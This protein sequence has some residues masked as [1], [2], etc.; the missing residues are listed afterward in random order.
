MRRHSTTFKIPSPEPQINF[1]RQLQKLKNEILLEALQRTLKRAK[2][3]KLDGDLHEFV[4]EKR[5]QKVRSYGMSGEVVFVTPY[6]LTLNPKLIGYYRLLI[7]R[8]KKQFYG[9]G[10]FGV[11]SSME[12][13][14]WMTKK[15][16]PLMTDLC[17]SMNEATWQLISGIS[18]N[19][20]VESI[21]EL[22]LLTLGPQLRGGH[23]VEI[24][25]DATEELFQTF[26][27]TLAPMNP[28]VK[29]KK[30]QFKNGLGNEV[31]IEFGSDPDIKIYERTSPDSKRDLVAIEI[32]GGTDVSNLHNR[33]GEAE[34]SHLKARGNGF[35]HFWTILRFKGFDLKRAKVESPTTEHFFDITELGNPNSEQSA[36]FL[37]L[38]RETL[39]LN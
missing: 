15:Q 18:K 29:N 37:R 2:L 24:G 36:S 22:T 27:H 17:I 5:L 3:K 33:L 39:S 10:G 20:T 14:G 30:I 28:I 12:E 13:K 23:N 1:F 31:T 32:K 7:G 19:L 35:P 8:S 21:R 25:A 26:Q 6:I 4:P 34:K 9:Q 11:F 16:Q 38:L